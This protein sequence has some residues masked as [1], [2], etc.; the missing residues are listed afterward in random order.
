VQ[1]SKG[2]GDLKSLQLQGQTGRQQQSTTLQSNTV[3]KKERTKKSMTR[4]VQ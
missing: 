2:S 1:D 3:R 4:N